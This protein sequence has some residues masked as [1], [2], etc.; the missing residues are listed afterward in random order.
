MY[1]ALKTWKNTFLNENLV[2]IVYN[3]KLLG[4]H[5]TMFYLISSLYPSLFSLYISFFFFPFPFLFFF[6]SSVQHVS[7]WTR[8][9]SLWS[10]PQAAQQQVPCSP[11]QMQCTF[12][13]YSSRETGMVRPALP[14]S[15]TP[16]Q[17]E[18]ATPWLLVHLFESMTSC[19]PSSQNCTGRSS[20]SF[21]RVTM[22][23]WVKSWVSWVSWW[24][25]AYYIHA[26]CT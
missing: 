1:S 25:N 19:S 18:R 17:T 3:L 22:V 16:A 20:S 8:G 7:W 10:H 9:S 21:M 2:G 6:L 23:S 12:P 26:I 14:A 13:I 24:P 5:L 11:W 15:S 4:K